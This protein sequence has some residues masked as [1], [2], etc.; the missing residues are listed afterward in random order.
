[1][2]GTVRPSGADNVQVFVLLRIG[3][4][5]SWTNG[6]VIKGKRAS[7]VANRA[8]FEITPEG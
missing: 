6:H 1:M 7:D 8:R 3:A 4:A 5:L 2:T